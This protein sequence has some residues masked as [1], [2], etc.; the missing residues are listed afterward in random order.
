M[1][2]CVVCVHVHVWCVNVCMVCEWSVL[3]VCVACA[4]VVCGVCA[5]VCMRV[6][7]HMCIVC[8]VCVEQ[9]SCLPE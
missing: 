2:V 5:C 8:V 3:C 6:H 4:C 1:L 9:L 7:V